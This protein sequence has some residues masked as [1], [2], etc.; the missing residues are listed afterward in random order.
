LIT[1]CDLLVTHHPLLSPSPPDHFFN[2]HRQQPA[3]GCPGWTGL[4]A[5]HTNYDIATDGLN[6]LLADRI[7][8]QQTRPLKITSRDE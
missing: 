3:A 5:M 1:T 6:D 8:L 4:L 2:L 7:G